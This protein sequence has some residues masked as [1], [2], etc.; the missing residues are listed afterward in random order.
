MTLT[1]FPQA[2]TL[3]FR[4]VLPEKHGPVHKPMMNPN[5]ARNAR[6]INEFRLANKTR[7]RAAGMVRR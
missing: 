3:D 1:P 5:T 7:S 4:A 2:W 6:K